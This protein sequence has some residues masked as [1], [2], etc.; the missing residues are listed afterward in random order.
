M[1]L[2]TEIIES[3]TV[4]KEPIAD[5]LRR[6]LVLAFKLKNDTLKEWLEH[7]LNGYSL[8]E[9]L[10]DY[11]QTIGRAKGIFFGPFGQQ[12][13]DQPLAPGIMSP[14]HQHW[15]RDIKLR[16][17]IAAYDL[18]SENGSARI[19]WPADL[20]VLYQ[21][22][23]IDGMAL[24]RAWIEIPTSVMAG[25]KDTIRTRVLTLVLEI[26]DELPADTD[27]AVEEIPPA[28]VDRIVYQIILG[29]TNVF[30]NVNEFNATTVMAGD[31]KSL[32]ASLKKLGITDEDFRALETSLK[33]DGT[34]SIDAAR[35]MS[36]GK[37][38]MKWITA[39]GTKAG[40]GAVKISAAVA[41]EAIKAAIKRY[42]G[43]DG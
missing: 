42:L 1:K 43:L 27:A 28:V 4:T 36:L 19:E 11:R 39:A 10:P 20:V 2:L 22:K 30:G 16:Q 14:E 17:P 31:L 8:D 23:F 35:P 21:E 38:T 9:A 3:V 7:E 5:I 32:E 34:Y 12:I 40:G 6:C 37:K 41:E 26:Q 15:A 13:N 25:L 24:N 33:E 29:G 18:A